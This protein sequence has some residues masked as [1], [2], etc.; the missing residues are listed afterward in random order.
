MT[1]NTLQEQLEALN[2]RSLRIVARKLK[3][4][5]FKSQGK[6]DLIRIIFDAIDEATIRKAAALSWWDIH[7]SQVF[8]FGG[9]ALGLLGVILALVSVPKDYSDVPG[10][11]ATPAL[12]STS[13][14]VVAPTQTPSPTPVDSQTPNPSNHTPTE[15]DYT[16][17]E[18]VDYDGNIIF[19]SDPFIYYPSTFGPS[20]VSE[21]IAIRHGVAESSLLWSNLRMLKFQSRQEKNN[22]GT[23][24]WRHVVEATL[25]NGS[26]VNV[27]L[28]DDWNMAYMGGGGTGLLF[29][30][31]SLLG[32][33]RIP[34]SN[35]SV[36]KVL[37][38]S[39]PQT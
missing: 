37:K 33:I 30:R 36:L 7:Q 1:D 24:V 3:I 34:F 39:S 10:Q 8:G 28:Q 26:V 11:T 38:Y 27:E 19:L 25:A 32:E 22:E 14:S 35:I 29:G 17:L 13:P 6:A 31:E 12:P 9:L 15:A 20:K 18:I 4:R 21:G 16:E 5:N 23:V 2:L